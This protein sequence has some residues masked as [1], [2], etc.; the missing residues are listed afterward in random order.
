MCQ[1]FAIS[2]HHIGRLI[3]PSSS[4]PPTAPADPILALGF[5][6]VI[7][8]G[9]INSEVALAK[10]L[11]EKIPQ[12]GPDGV[13]RGAGAGE[14]GETRCAGVCVGIFA[15]QCHSK[16]TPSPDHSSCRTEIVLNHRVASY[17]NLLHLPVLYNIIA[18]GQ[19]WAHSVVAKFP[20]EPTLLFHASFGIAVAN[21]IVFLGATL[22]DRKLMTLRQWLLLQVVVLVR[23]FRNRMRS[24]GFGVVDSCNNRPLSNPLYSCD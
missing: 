6:A 21:S 24:V 22:K 5:L 12:M 14:A 4:P 7:I 2:I 10:E 18:G 13:W 9:I 1:P 11:E 23:R 19:A 3:A 16:S 8:H 17:P 20:L 15:E